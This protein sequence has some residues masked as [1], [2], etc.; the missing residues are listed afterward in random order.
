MIKPTKGNIVVEYLEEE[1][2][3]NQFGIVLPSQKVMRDM[4]R[5]QERHRI[6]IDNKPPDVYRWG[7]YV[8]G[9]S[10][11]RI[12]DNAFV[13]YNRHDAHEFTYEGIQYLALPENL[14]LAYYVP[15]PTPEAAT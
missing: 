6:D 13:Y 12:P 5:K 1:W 3:A 8:A 11:E 7:R 4:L 2:A 15:E 10:R 14:A 9:E